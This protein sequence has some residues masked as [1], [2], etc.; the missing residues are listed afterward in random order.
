MNKLAVFAALSIAANS[1]Y[2]PVDEAYGDCFY[3]DVTT[4]AYLPSSYVS[5]DSA[6]YATTDYNS[7]TYNYAFEV[8]LDYTNGEYYC[9]NVFVSDFALHW[10]LNASDDDT[11]ITITYEEWL[12]DATTGYCTGSYADSASTAITAPAGLSPETDGYCAYDVYFL[13]DDGTASG[14][15]TYMSIHVFLDNSVFTAAS[16]FAAAGVA[17]I[18]FF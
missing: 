9:D 17:S 11:M 15:A 6:V 13:Y 10:T 7:V 4:E 5:A 1:M 12:V 3:W 8:V 16:A 18:F 2:T 14:S